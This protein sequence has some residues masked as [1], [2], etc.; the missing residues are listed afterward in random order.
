MLRSKPKALMAAH[1][2]M[3]EVLEALAAMEAATE[4]RAGAARRAGQG[5]S[6]TRE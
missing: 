3:E 5:R 2:A 6:R 4:A 1:A